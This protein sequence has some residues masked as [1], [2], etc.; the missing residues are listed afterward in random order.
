MVLYHD[1]RSSMMLIESNHT[2]TSFLLRVEFKWTRDICIVLRNSRHQEPYPGRM[3]AMELSADE[4]IDNS[5]RRLGR[6]STGAYATGVHGGVTSPASARGR[7][8]AV[9]M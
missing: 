1:I 9:P 3:C 4:V 5:W 7:D 8:T 6:K 2:Q